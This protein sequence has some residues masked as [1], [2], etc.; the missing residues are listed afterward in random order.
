MM[1]KTLVAVSGGIGSGKSVV[2]RVL[3]ALG[4]SIYDC[5]SR[6]KALM[7]ADNNIKRRIA[8][9]IH[10]A[11]ISDDMSIN[12]DVLSRIVFSD[13][14]KLTVLNSIVH[15]AVR[16]DIRA[17]AH[18]KNERLLFVETAILYQSGL[19]AMVDAVWEVTAPEHVRVER[20]MRR[21]GLCKSDVMRR[22]Q[23]QA[24]FPEKPHARVSVIT[25]DDRRSILMQIDALLGEISAKQ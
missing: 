11:A 6:A 16:D 25:N 15:A 21:N 10:A 24:F 20:V 19:D 1:E 5:D 22:I 8:L 7:D 18:E 4:Y 13:Q 17:W 9:E 3:A 23:S 12:R 14:S 2:C